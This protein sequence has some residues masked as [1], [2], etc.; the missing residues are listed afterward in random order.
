MQEQRLPVHELRVGMFVAEL[1]RPWLDTPFLLQGFL[2]ENEATLAQLCSICEYVVIDR[3]RSIGLPAL[4]AP[5]QN[6]AQPAESVPRVVTS[7]VRVEEGAAPARTG[8]NP[9]TLSAE[10]TRTTPS[11]S[12]SGAGRPVSEASSIIPSVSFAAQPAGHSHAVEDEGSVPAASSASWPL[13]FP[14]VL[15][16]LRTLWSS[17][18]KDSG[19][20]SA[21]SKAWNI[22]SPL[23]RIHKRVQGLD[24]ELMRASQHYAKANEVLQNIV[25][26]IRLG[27]G[28]EIEAVES[29]VEDLVESI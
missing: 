24:K 1:D 2:I 23:I 12:S 4:S 11:P 17:Q 21:D 18:A 5:A 28:L 6:A 8:K 29:V 16:W 14:N 27:K 3:A 26:D 15:G 13:S 10:T 25:R 9:D 22:T 20:A 7:F 19:E